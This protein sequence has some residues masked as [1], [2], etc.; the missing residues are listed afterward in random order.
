MPRF[1]A[2]A[3][4]AGLLTLGAAPQPEILVFAAASLTESLQEI[5][6]AYEAKT[7][8]K[9]VYSFGP[10]SD[11]QRQIS[12]GAP[13]DVFFS[14]DTPKMHT[15]E[16]AGLVRKAD[17]REFLSNVL[18]VVVPAN[19]PT[20]P[21]NAKELA[22][23]PKIALADPAAV[24][25]GIYAK[26]WLESEGLWK[27]V[28]PK[29]VPA[30]DVRAALAAVASGAVPA[31]VVYSTD[32]ASSKGVRIAFTVTNGPPIAYSVAVLAG[33]KHAAE[34][35]AFVKFVESD[36]GKAVFKRRGFRILGAQ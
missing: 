16:K 10:S 31:G 14:A 17:R 27:Q 29:V 4:L 19:S 3:A 22:S 35:R 13:A 15:L 12:A 9:V 24:P 30:L 21:A 34:A 7:G 28:A 26:K 2:Y 36:E 8:T 1:G 6:M 11:L 18:V 33:S 23:L 32:A 5:G 25:A 20:L